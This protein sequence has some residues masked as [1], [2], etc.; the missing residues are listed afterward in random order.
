VGV[1]KYVYEFKTGADGKLAATAQWNRMEQTGTTELKEVKLNG[2]AISFVETFTIPDGDA[3]V[4]IEY[5]GTLA[6]DEM[7]LTR[8]V[9]DFAT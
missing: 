2:A 9:G 6:G 1:Q 8:T 5:K 7:K 3:E 4:R